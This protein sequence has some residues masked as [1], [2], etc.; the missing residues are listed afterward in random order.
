MIKN[1][2]LTCIFVLAIVLSSGSIFQYSKIFN[3]ILLLVII[4]LNIIALINA[5]FKFDKK[6]IN[7][8]IP[9]ILYFMLFI[10]INNDYRERYISYLL[11]TIPIITYVYT[12]K[13]K[14]RDFLNELSKIIFIYSIVTLIIWGIGIVLGDSIFNVVF[15]NEE[16]NKPYYNFYN[17]FSYWQTL[18]INGIKIIK[19]SGIFVE[20]GRFAVFLIMALFNNIILD[21]N[22]K[23]FKNCIL[24]ITLIT[25]FS[26]TGLISGIMIIVIR[27]LNSSKL[28]SIHFFKVS[29][30]IIIA[31]FGSIYILNQKINDEYGSKSY[32]TRIVDMKIGIEVL[33]DRPFIGYGFGNMN[34][35]GERLDI[36]NSRGEGNGMSNGITTALIYG[37]IYFIIYFI[38]A[39]IVFIKKYNNFTIGIWAILIIIFNIVSQ[40]I[41][42][43]PIVTYLAISSFITKKYI[44]IDNGGMS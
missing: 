29:I 21:K 30:I 17:I 12:S 13:I 6:G 40:P 8:V 9:I 22:E 18:S 10:F 42:F 25:T 43:D 24:F 7:I 27:Y 1:K 31:L 3:Y 38:L 32:N 19:N 11:L 2:Y 36:S 23:K 28:N 41:T 5:K 14:V 37:G 16:Y 20:S 44:N 26:T 15:Y 34:I 33:K 4:L 35:I 39:I